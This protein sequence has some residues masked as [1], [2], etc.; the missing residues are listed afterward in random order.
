MK[1]NIIIFFIVLV[2]S[3]LAYWMNKAPMVD[4]HEAIIELTD[5][6][7]EDK[8]LKSKLPILVDFWA[9]WCGPCKQ[10]A[11]IVNE[12][13]ESYKGKLLVGKVDVDKFP[14]ISQ[15]C[16]IRGIPTL[17]L[18]KDGKLVERIVG[19]VPKEQLEA[20]IKAHIN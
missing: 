13:A 15:K 8:I 20:K 11:P 19:A 2:V 18:F 16:E 5:D 17:L 9:A 1:R 10:I 4:N 3:G 6:N 7:F 12:L 14:G